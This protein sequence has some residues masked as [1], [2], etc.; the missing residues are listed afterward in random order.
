[1]LEEYHTYEDIMNKL[2]HFIIFTVLNLSLNHVCFSKENIKF[3]KEGPLNFGV[4]INSEQHKIYRSKALGKRG[5]AKLRS[6]MK[7]N[8]YDFP[9]IIIYMNRHGY[10]IDKSHLSDFAMQ[11]YDMQIEYGFSFYHSFRYDYRTYLD[12][13]NPY[14]P[15]EDIDGSEYLGV[16]AVDYFGL[17]NDQKVDGGIDALMRIMELILNSKT[18]VLFHCAGGLHRTGMI[19]MVIRYIQG[20]Q[21]IEGKKKKILVGLGEQMWL[22]PAQYEYYLHNRFQFR[23]ENIKFIEEFTKSDEFDLLVSQFRNSLN[24]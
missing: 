13:E 22:N 12:G 7:D 20:G 19:A 15:S 4:L 18:P 10:K 9:E 8:H 1:M 16:R 5:L 3:S 21:W 23:Y 11:E 14:F 2:K 17:E 6:Y 24:N